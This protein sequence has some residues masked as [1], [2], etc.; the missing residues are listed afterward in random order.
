MR[1]SSSDFPDAGGPMISSPRLV[2]GD[3]VEELKKRLQSEQTIAT[4]SEHSISDEKKDGSSM[5][6]LF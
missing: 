3:E 2:T 4:V 6:E 1:R 5:A